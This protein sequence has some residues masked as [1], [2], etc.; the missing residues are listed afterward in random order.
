MAKERLMPVHTLFGT[1]CTDAEEKRTTGLV[2]RLIF[3]VLS[4]NPEN[5][6]NLRDL[7]K[8]HSELDRP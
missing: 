2:V 3:R 8:V 6:K 5:K 1:V 4:L 7:C